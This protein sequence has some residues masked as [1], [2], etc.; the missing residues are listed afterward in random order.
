MTNLLNLSSSPHI[1]N[2]LTTNQIMYRVLLSL[3]PVTIMG[4]INYGMGALS[5]I[6]AAVAAAVASEA[7]FQ[8]IIKR[9]ITVTD[10]SAAVTGLML[11]LI[12]PPELPMYVPILGSVFA[13]VVVKGMFGGLGHN[14]MNPALAARCFVLICYGAVV[15]VY[16]VDGV[17]MAT[18]LVDLAAGESVELADMFWGTAS[19]SIGS[20]VFGILIGA[21][22]MFGFKVISYEIPL[23]MIVSF[24]L[25]METVGGNGTD[26]HA[27]LVNIMGGGLLLGAFFMATDYVT[28]PV[29]KRGRLIFGTLIG[30][31][32]GLFR[33]YGS[34]SDSVSYAI[35]FANILVPLIEEHTIPAAYGYRKQT[36][37]KKLEIPGSA[38]TL[39]II[40]VIAGVALSGV[41]AMTKDTIAGQKLAQEQ[42]SYQAVCP[43]AVKFVT[44]EAIETW[45]A[46][47]ADSVY[48]TEFGKIT[49]N[50][51]LL[52]KDASGETIG[53]V[54]S[55]TSGDGFDGD[56]VMSV[57][58]DPEGLVTGIEFTTITE[59]TGM[60]MLVK[61]PEFKNQYL[62][63]E[64][65]R[66][67]LHKTGGTSK[68]N[69]IDGVSGATFSSTAVTN[70]VN[71][72]MDF[73]ENQIRSEGR[74]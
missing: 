17:A 30:L 64:T 69:E 35:I 4:I 73:F 19:G 68:A 9:P 11:A 53:C 57:G 14:F 38:V 63:V 31:L 37:K 8:A 5:V 32:C 45:I 1:R 18:P 21:A 20:S 40:T 29:T 22:M 41:Y 66:F 6:V 28:S 60:G 67:V 54:I 47:H 10:G 26:L 23:S 61:E 42:Q 34:A 55:V 71:A 50:K 49:I 65:D 33:V 62:G 16:K 59:T 12:L 51:A 39:C 24:T 25:F 15:T 44:D 52:G 48:G 72:A 27:L 43:D 36:E 46:A 70:A 13:I 7:V 2:S 3:M 74:L 58:L 56:I